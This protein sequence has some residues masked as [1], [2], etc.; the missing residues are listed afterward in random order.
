MR[1]AGQRLKCGAPVRFESVRAIAPWSHVRPMGEDI[2]A[3]QLI[4]PAGSTL[5]AVDLGAIAAAGF[6]T[7]EVARKPKGGD[8]SNRV[9]AGS[10]GLGSR[11]SRHHRIQLA[12]SGGHG[13]RAGRHRRGALTLSATTQSC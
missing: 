6:A 2:V 11:A 1:L 7:V 3:T 8:H 4:L 13:E 12:G 10:A 9:R 5:R